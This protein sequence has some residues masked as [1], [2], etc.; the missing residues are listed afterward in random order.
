VALLEE[1]K[2]GAYIKG[3]SPVGMAKVVSLEWFGDQ[4]VKVTFEDSAGRVG[5]RLVF[6]NE[7]PT[8]EVV[9]RG[10]PWSF[11]GDGH[12][13]RLASEAYR[14][15]LAYLFD[16]YLAIHTSQV[17]PLPHQITAVYGAML[18]RQPLRFLL[19]DDP[20]AGKTIMAGLLIKELL[21]RGDLERCLIVTPG[22]L[23]EQWQDEL[24]QKFGLTFDILTRDQIEASRSGNPFSERHL[25]IARLDMLSRNEALKEKLKVGPEWDLVICDEAHRLSAS[26]FGEEVKFTKRYR[27]GQTVGSHCRHFLLMTATPHNGKEEDFQLF[28][29]LLDGD[30][31]EGRFRDGVHKTDSSDMLRRLT[32]EELR[33]FDGRPLFP[34]RCAY[35][36]N[37]HL[38]DQEAALYTAVTTYVRQEMNR[39]ERFAGTDD[40]RKQNVG[41]A[42]QAL[43]RR[44]ASSPAAIH[45]SL[46]RRRERLE[47]RLTEEQLLARGEQALI[48][49]EN[50]LAKSSVEELEDLEDTPER[51]V[52]EAEERILDRATAARTIAELQTEITTLK[53]LEAQAKALRQSGV[54]TKW[55]ELNSVLDHPLMVD[56]QGNRRKLILFTE[57]RDSLNYLAEKIRTRLGRPEAVVVIHGGVGREDRRKAVEAFT[58]DKDVLVMVA[59]DAAGEGINLQRAHLM[60]NYDLPWNPNR[61]EQRFGRIHRIGQ[62]EVCHLW[63]LVAAD[64]REGEVYSR[65]LKKLET[66]REALGGRVYDVLGRLFEGNALRDLLVEAIRYGDQPEVKERLFRAVDNAVDQQHLLD[67][68][69]E[70]ALVHD[71]LTTARI[72]EIREHMER[73]QARRLQ[74]HFIQS[75][76]LEAFSHLD[77]RI[78]PR[79]P[80]R[81]EITYVPGPVR[82]RDRLI[83]IGEPV[84]PHYER[85]CFEKDKINQTPVAAFICPGHP[86]MAATIDLVLER[87]RELLKRGAVL[88]DDLDEGDRLRVLFYLEQAV[89]DGRRGRN[90]EQ[91]VISQQL[92]FVEYRE[93]GKLYDAGPAPYL[94]YRPIDAEERTAIAPWLEAAWLGEDIENK[95]ISHAIQTVVP[96]HVEEIRVR[97]LPYIDKV[98]ME[99]EVRLKKEIN[100]WDRRAEDLKAQERAGKQTRLS[101][102]NAAARADEL[103]DRLQRRR[104]ELNKERQISALPP[105]VRGGAIV[106]PGGLLKKVRNTAEPTGTPADGLAREA[107]EKLAMQAVIAAERALGRL[108]R[109][110]SEQKGLGYDIESRDPQTGSLFF[111]EV[112]GRWMD[113]D[114]VTLTKNEILCS[115]N[116]PDKFRLALVRVGEEGPHAPRYLRGFPLGEPDFAETTRTFSLRKLLEV[117]GEP[118]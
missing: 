78:Y 116:E 19:A 47:K 24:A 26:F 21:V 7:E 28:L 49:E 11:D 62:Q 90:Q 50:T 86:L 53:Q 56:D 72:A 117:S 42:L 10:R 88:V 15:R 41:F 2:A 107:I 34:E 40:K 25:L 17:E 18:P 87:H 43:Q 55:V 64:T 23:V 4:S 80:G 75:F 65:L 5:N 110:V 67:L 35:T 54:D 82:E 16:P 9:H 103:A 113:K 8:L 101:S 29:A 63:N 100:H 99:V 61:I 45:E 108:P 85:V 58:H 70:R 13:L 81:W 98:E 115:R 6:R 52:E 111:I 83:G 59:N 73:A 12:L 92:Q 93:D 51:E 1:L 57:P 79:E 36:V 109:D 14:I 60:V 106:V 46:R 91:Q 20:G 105:V 69:A 94:D 96:R 22:N 30:R 68:L 44:L 102:A 71:T 118:V 27:L 38:S 37:Y 104:D 112:K 95:V 84:M 114:E 31:F 97:K 3:L 39:V 32:K 76:F 33:K 48:H 77:G 74:P 89:Q 66:A